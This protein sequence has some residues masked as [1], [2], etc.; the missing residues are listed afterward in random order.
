MDLPQNTSK[1][2]QYG[3]VELSLLSGSLFS[4]ELSGRRSIIS[5][6]CWGIRSVNTLKPDWGKAAVLAE[7]VWRGCSDHRAVAVTLSPGP[8]YPDAR[9]LSAFPMNEPVRRPSAT[10]GPGDQAAWA[11]IGFEMVMNWVALS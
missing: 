7:N 11:H 9:V 3:F 5:V 8:N 6:D 4:P 2:V 10:P 1:W